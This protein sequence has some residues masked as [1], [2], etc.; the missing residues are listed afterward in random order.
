MDQLRSAIR[1]Q[2]LSRRTE[3]AYCGW[4]RRFILFHHKRH[5]SEMREAALAAFLTALATRQKVSASTQN[6]A[7]AAILFLYKHVLGRPL[8]LV[9][10]VVHAKR[11][12]RVPVVLTRSETSALL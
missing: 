10:G 11:P 3:A 8:G 2:H 5:P 1:S 6:Q 7:L 9:E 12:L 4:I